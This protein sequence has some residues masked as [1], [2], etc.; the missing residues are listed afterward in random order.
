VTNSRQ[1]GA[2]GENKL[3]EFL[4]Q[5]AGI[6]FTRTPGSGSGKIKGDLMCPK[7]RFCIEVK[8]YKEDP[9]GS[10]ILCNKSSLIPKWWKKVKGEAKKQQPLIFYRWNRSK[11]FVVTQQKPTNTKNYLDFPLLGCYILL[12]KEWIDKEEIQWYHSSS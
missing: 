8:N 5:E 1:K 7:G 3:I 12:A 6:E 11:W 4:K 2:T 10:T 9:L